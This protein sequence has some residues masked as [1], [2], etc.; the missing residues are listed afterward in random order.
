MK[1]K[2]INFIFELKIMTNNKNNTTIMQSNFDEVHVTVGEVDNISRKCR[3]PLQMNA[4]KDMNA[5]CLLAIY[6]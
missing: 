3:R 6:E 2:R 5:K 1:L 4:D